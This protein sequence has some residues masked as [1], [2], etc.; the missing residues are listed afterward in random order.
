M[1]IEAA[2]QLIRKPGFI[3]NDKKLRAL[4]QSIFD[5]GKE[6]NAEDLV[7]QQRSHG[8]IAFNDGTIVPI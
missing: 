6:R 2:I 8:V 4:L 5:L 3:D 7:P 1:D